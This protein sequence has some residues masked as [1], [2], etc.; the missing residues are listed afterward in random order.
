MDNS[1]MNV[2]HFKLVN[3]EEIIALVQQKHDCSS[4]KK[5]LGMPAEFSEKLRVL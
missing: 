1:K 5:L 2:R 4:L 3:G